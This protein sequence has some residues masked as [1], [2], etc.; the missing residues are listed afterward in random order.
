MILYIAIVV[1]CLVGILIP[2]EFLD[3]KIAPFVIGGLIL[4]TTIITQCVTY[5]HQVY[6][7]ERINKQYEFKKIQT[8]KSDELISEF[9][10]YL[11]EIYPDIEKNIFD[12]IKP[13]NVTVYMMKYPEI[14]SSETITKLVSLIN[15]IKGACYSYD[16]EISRIQQKIRVREKTIGMICLPI[17]PKYVHQE[18]NEGVWKESTFRI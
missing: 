4:I 9:K 10:L 8:K 5:Y 6:D 15:S 1:S 14:K 13:D 16:F 7:I 3:A 2:S 18:Y 11:A 12:S 17:L